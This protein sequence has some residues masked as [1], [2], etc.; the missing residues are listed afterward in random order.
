MR[1]RF[2]HGGED[3]AVALAP[4]TPRRRA[5][6]R[7][8]AELGPIPR[9]NTP[10]RPGGASS[11]CCWGWSGCY[12]MMSQSWPTA[13][14]SRPTRSTRSRARSRRCWPRRSAPADGNG[15]G[16]ASASPE[17]LASADILGPD[18]RAARRAAASPSAGR[19]YGRERGGRGRGGRGRGRGGRRRGRRRRSRPGPARGA[20]EDE[21]DDEDEDEE[22]PTTRTSRGARRRRRPSGRATPMRSRATGS[23]RAR[24]RRSRSP[25]SPRTRT[26]PSASGSSTPPAPARRSRRW[27]SWRRRRRAGC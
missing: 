8:L 19:A 9:P 15:R 22:E 18:G 7:A 5:L 12:R 1:E 16:A 10:R 24:T 25:T 4:G 23:R 3:P 21:D 26:R 6:D 2:L 17:L 11:R 27:A 14:C 20:R 13:P